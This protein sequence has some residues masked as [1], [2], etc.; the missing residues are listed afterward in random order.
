M[1]TDSSSLK[2]TNAILPKVC[3]NRLLE[4]REGKF[5]VDHHFAFLTDFMKR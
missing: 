4:V 2:G 5:D 3:K 1:L